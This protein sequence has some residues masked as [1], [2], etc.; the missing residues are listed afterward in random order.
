MLSSYPFTQTTKAKE[1]N[2]YSYNAHNTQALTYDNPFTYGSR[3]SPD[4]TV[5]C[6]FFPVQHFFIYQLW[7]HTTDGQLITPLAKTQN[8]KPHSTYCDIIII[9]W[10][11]WTEVNMSH[12]R[13]ELH[14]QHCQWERVKTF[15]AGEKKAAILLGCS[16]GVDHGSAVVLHFVTFNNKTLSSWW[17]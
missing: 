13:C 6:P 4:D 14:L 7:K 16:P 2:G 3:W 15:R 12:L 17:M 5:L 10:E 11:G 9:R 1:L 8:L